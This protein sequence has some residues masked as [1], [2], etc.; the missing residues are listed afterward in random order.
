MKKFIKTLAFLCIAFGVIDFVIAEF[1]D[2]WLTNQ[3]YPFGSLENDNLVLVYWTPYAFGVVGLV[4]Y[5]IN[6]YLLKPK[7][8]DL[9][10]GSLKM[11]VSRYV[12]MKNE[13]GKLYITPEKITFDATETIDVAYRSIRTIEKAKIM[14]LFPAIKILTDDE[15]YLFGGFANRNK[16]IN[17]INNFRG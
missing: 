1:M 17:A 4:L 8:V 12:G 2:V 13:Q 15:E 11:V 3:F 10:E 6:I 16:V 5:Y 9:A 7:S 14:F